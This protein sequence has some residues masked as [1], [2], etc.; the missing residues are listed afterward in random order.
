MTI[1]IHKIT[2]YY[3]ETDFNSII[4]MY[5]KEEY[6]RFFL[7]KSICR[8][9]VFK[10]FNKYLSDKSISQV[11]KVSEWLVSYLNYPEITNDILLNFVKNEYKKQIG[12]INIEEVISQLSKLPFFDWWGIYQNALEWKIVKYI[13]KSYDFEYIKWLLEWEL[14][15]SYINYWL[16]SWYNY[17]SS[18]II[19]YYFKSHKKIIPTVWLIKHVD[20][21]FDWIPVDL[22]VTYLPQEYVDIKRK[23]SW[24]DKEFTALK[25]SMKNISGIDFS[26]ENQWTLNHALNTARNL[27]LD[28]FN[29]IRNFRN[30]LAN[31]LGSNRTELNLL[32]SWLYEN[33]W[34][35]RYDNS[36]R[37]FLIC[38]DDIDITWAWQ[39]KINKWLQAKIN[40]FLDIWANFQY[41]TYNWNGE[42]KETLASVLIIN[43][44]SI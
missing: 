18:V 42:E 39:M 36:Y 35:R 44:S 3:D 27:N 26:N 28:I 34:T 9:E 20:F 41:I 6:I 24:L 7:L 15:T 10:E 2:K 23:N 25:N 29:E 12:F 21:I 33:Q 17:W 32:I 38:I 11:K 19:E 1:E 13:H 43:K 40:S 31:D 5:S 16:S 30:K 14:F 37:I 4:K 8:W 22:K